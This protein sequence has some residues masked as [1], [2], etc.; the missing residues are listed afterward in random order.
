MKSKASEFSKCV[1]YSC[2]HCNVCICRLGKFG[3]QDVTS[4][5]VDREGPPGEGYS[6]NP[7]FLSAFAKLR[8]ATVNFVI[9]V[10]SAWYSVA[11]TRRIFLKVDVLVCFE[12][13][14]RKL[15]FN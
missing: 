5:S 9:S 15:K 8:I 4:H 1:F 10:L 12:N 3:L 7:H 13:M 14:S 6:A 2:V 11:P